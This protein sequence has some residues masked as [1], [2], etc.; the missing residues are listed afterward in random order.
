MTNPTPR[1]CPDC[2][3][4]GHILVGRRQN[5]SV[6]ESCSTCDGCGMVIL[7]PAIPADTLSKLDDDGYGHGI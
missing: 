7:T 4:M 6:F 1:P 2:G 5:K 3:G